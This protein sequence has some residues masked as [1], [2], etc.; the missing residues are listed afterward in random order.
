MKQGKDVP[1]E[2]AP[3]TIAIHAG[4][5]ARVPDG[6]LNTPVV[7]TSTYHAGGPVGYGRDGNVTWSAFEEVLGALEG[8]RALAFA[9]GMGA[10][11]AVLEGLPV[12]SRVVVP[13]TSYIGTR[14][15]L[16]EGAERSRFEVQQVE[17]T[18]TRATLLACEG[19]RL[20]WIESPTNPLLGIADIAALCEGAHRRGLQVAVDNTFATPLLQRPLD[21]GAD[22][23][24]HSATKYLSGH[25]DIVMGAVV[26]RREDLM[27]QL[28]HRREMY[29]AIPGPMEA[30]LALR[31]VR[32]LPLRL[33]RAQRNAGELARRLKGHPRVSRVRYPGLADD[34]GHERAARQMK[35]FGAMVSF[36][37]RGG[38]EAAETVCA[39]V[40]VLTHGTSLGG[41]ETLIE[42]RSKWRG[43][44]RTPPDLLRMSVGCEDVEDLWRDLDRALAASASD[45]G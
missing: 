15:F 4:R 39:A 34:P 33:E 41:I 10:A 37:V 3:A 36:E 20:L 35:G 38:A 24:V 1:R 2:L 21:L 31:G 17:V 19:A 22:V 18:D 45:P 28:R 27:D 13:A 23:V 44:E 29:G 30:F 16:S 8:G 43:E 26:T 5:P 9:S 42:R 40:R 14:E 25:S 12:G 6:P 32:T 11:T 7:F